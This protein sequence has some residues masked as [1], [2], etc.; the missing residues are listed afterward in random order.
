MGRNESLENAGAVLCCIG[1]FLFALGVIIFLIRCFSKRAKLPAVIFMTASLLIAL[2]G[3]GT[4]ASNF[5][6]DTR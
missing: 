6:I 4:C 5:T 3:F 1:L 2:I